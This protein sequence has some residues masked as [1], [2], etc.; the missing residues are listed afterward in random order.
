MPALRLVAILVKRSFR[1]Y[2]LAG[3]DG[4]LHWDHIPGLGHHHKVERLQQK[5][6]HFYSRCERRSILSG[7]NW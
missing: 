4:L 2:L 7:R 6:T 5:K 3:R 1:D